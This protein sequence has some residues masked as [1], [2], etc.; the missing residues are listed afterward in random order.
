M[1]Y[2][3]EHKS[4][5]KARIL[6]AAAREIRAS[7]PGGIAIGRIM[8]AAGLTHGAFYA[9]FAS[10]EDLVAQ[11]LGAMFDGSNAASGRLA[12]ALANEDVD[13]RPALKEFL[14]NYLSPRHREGVERGCP[15]PALAADM[16]RSQGAAK[17]SFA[18]GARRLTA[19]IS[20]VLERM[21]IAA[22][23]A[24]ARTVVAQIAGAVALARAIGPGPD[25]DA[26]LAD[27]LAALTV[28]F[29]L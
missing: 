3:A 2:A 17:D 18:D 1:R 22:P 25:S 26:I 23:D 10:K 13:L 28:R 7:G 15:L 4:R 16:A 6:D 29:E 12:L 8:S 5:S 21:G 24:E 11:A 27:N 9:H 20:V 14:A 19:R